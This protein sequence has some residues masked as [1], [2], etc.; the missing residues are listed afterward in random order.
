MK[1][2]GEVENKP[3]RLVSHKSIKKGKFRHTCDDE[4]GVHKGQM[5]EQPKNGQQP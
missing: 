4:E 1:D 2:A 3:M 5:Y